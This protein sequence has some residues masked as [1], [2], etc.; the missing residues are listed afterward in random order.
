MQ[1]NMH[2][3]ETCELAW[4]TLRP[5]ESAAGTLCG[6]PGAHSGDVYMSVDVVRVKPTGR[7]AAG[8]LVAIAMMLLGG[9]AGGAQPTERSG[10]EIVE[11]QCVKCHGSGDGGAPKIGDR[12][13]W[14]SRVKRGLDVVVRSA[15]RGHGAMPARGGMADLSDAEMRDAVVYMF[16]T[17]TGN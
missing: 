2:R 7:I 12:A 16:S 4:S 5:A 10:K 17:S 11:A 1:V 3:G 8:T 13:A 9:T 14:I 6:S 15:I